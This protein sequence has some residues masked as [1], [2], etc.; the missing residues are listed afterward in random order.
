MGSSKAK[1]TKAEAHAEAPEQTHSVVALDENGDT[2]CSMDLSKWVSG[3]AKG[4]TETSDWGTAVKASGLMS[5]KLTGKSLNGK[6]IAGFDVV[7]ELV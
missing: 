5:F 7:S 4:A 6:K 1:K 3:V 2:I